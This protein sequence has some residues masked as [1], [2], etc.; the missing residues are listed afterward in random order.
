MVGA[1]LLMAGTALAQSNDADPVPQGQLPSVTS[2][3][4][5]QPPMN[6]IAKAV[7]EARR[8]RQEAPQA[9]Q[10]AELP[11]KQVR[12]AKT[13]SAPAAGK[14]SAVPEEANR[15]QLIRNLPYQ[16]EKIVPPQAPSSEPISSE[17]AY[18]SRLVVCVVN[19]FERNNMSSS[20][21]KAEGGHVVRTAE[22]LRDNTGGKNK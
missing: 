11:S 18:S 2:E 22:V 17:V 5:A 16:P 20:D 8:R 15:N 12:P 9:A 13:D 4:P 6:P 14:S 1:I 10:G 21:C 7:A 19:G 3:A